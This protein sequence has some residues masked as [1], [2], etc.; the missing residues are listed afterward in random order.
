MDP[1]SYDG[2]VPRVTP[3]RGWFPRGSDEAFHHRFLNRHIKEIEPVLRGTMA[4]PP[5]EQS[6]PRGPARLHH[7][8]SS[9]SGE[10]LCPGFS[11]T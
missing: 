11:T 3:S 7:A 6:R 2:P 10:V 1:A 5:T 9:D 4:S 8:F